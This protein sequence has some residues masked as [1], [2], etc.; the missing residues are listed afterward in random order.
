MRQF[1][2]DVSDSYRMINACF[3][4]IRIKRQE[5]LDIFN[6]CIS[7]Q[8]VFLIALG[9]Y[10]LTNAWLPEIKVKRLD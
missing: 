8:N 4:E 7:E 1:W 9:Y 10:L 5:A 3:H 2:K 6:K